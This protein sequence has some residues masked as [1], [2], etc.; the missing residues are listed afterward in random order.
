VENIFED[1]FRDCKMLSSI[2]LPSNL[3][4]ISHWAFQNCTS[5]QSLTIPKSVTTIGNGA[6]YNS[7]IYDFYFYPQEAPTLG[8]NVFYGLMEDIQIHTKS[9][10]SGYTKEKGYV[11]SIIGDLGCEETGISKTLFYSDIY[12][13]NNK[14]YVKSSISE[15]IFVYSITGLKYTLK[16]FA[17]LNEFTLPKDIYI[18]RGKKIIIF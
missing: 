1:T 6:F 15:S 9:C 17:G 11:G 7:N 10:A 8:S 18:V 5:L 13:D 12:S 14:L 4:N 3:K 2:T 16:I